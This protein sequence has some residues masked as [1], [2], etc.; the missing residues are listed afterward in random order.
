[1]LVMSISKKIIFVSLSGIILLGVVALFLSLN[2][3]QQRGGAEA[4]FAR[5]MMMDEKKVNSRT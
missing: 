2:S 1:M 5:S 4:K 3:L